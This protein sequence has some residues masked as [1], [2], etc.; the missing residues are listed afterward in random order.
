[1]G[2]ARGAALLFAAG[3]ALL[4]APARGEA[5]PLASMSC[6]IEAGSGRLLCSVKV[7]APAGRSI[8]WSDALVVA[9]PSAARALRSRAASTSERPDQVVLAFVLG[10]GAG[11]RIAVVSRAVACPLAPRAGAC[12]PLTSRVGYDFEPPG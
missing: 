11:G 3:V 5:A 10:G 12:T 6:R 2:G 1:V 8:V 7:A 4:G 9:A